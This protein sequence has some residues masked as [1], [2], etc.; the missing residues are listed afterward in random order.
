MSGLNNSKMYH[1]LVSKKYL[2]PNTYIH[3]RHP[4]QK[5]QVLNTFH[6][7]PFE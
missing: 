6:I 3:Y 4:P 5:Y 1:S 2:M 7:F